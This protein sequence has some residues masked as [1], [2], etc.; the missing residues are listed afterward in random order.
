M[1]QYVIDSNILLDFPQII[2]KEKNNTLIIPTDVLRELDGLKLNQNSEIAF[3]ARRA[4]VVIS[5]NIENLEWDDSFEKERIPVDDKVIAVAQKHS[6]TLL[7][8]DVYVKV[9]A[10]IRGIS[11]KGYGN[12]NSYSGVVTTYLTMNDEELSCMVNE[13]RLPDNMMI[14]NENGDNEYLTLNENQYLIVKDLEQ[15]CI[16]NGI[17]DYEVLSIFCY[18]DGELVP[19]ALPHKLRIFNGWINSIGARNPE[20]SCLIDALNRE[21]NTIICAQ[22]CFGTG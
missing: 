7:T 5:H 18:K 19:I 13:H 6:A 15:P 20:Q 12:D 3:K 22:G 10:K 17:P 1:K 16:K 4:A 14:Q 21:E 8:N 11:T 2:E 9:K